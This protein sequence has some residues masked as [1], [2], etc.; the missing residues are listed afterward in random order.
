GLGFEPLAGDVAASFVSVGGDGYWRV[1]ER[2]G[3]NDRNVIV[4]STNTAP[5]TAV[6]IDRQGSL[7]AVG[8]ANGLVATFPI[9]GGTSEGIGREHGTRAVTQLTFSADGRRLAS[10]DEA[11]N[12]RLWT[13]KVI[14]MGGQDRDEPLTMAFT[15]RESPYIAYATDSGSFGLIDGYTGRADDVQQEVG[16]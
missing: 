11:G 15:P 6:T 1:W 7:V 14:Q 4:D 12:V 3:I 13:S 8:D 16:R 10:A 2:P 5:V 9:G